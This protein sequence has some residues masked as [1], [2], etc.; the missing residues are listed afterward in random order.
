M[1]SLN[2]KP[3]LLSLCLSAGLVGGAANAQAPKPAAPASAKQVP[4]TPVSMLGG[5]LSFTA[6]PGYE[7]SDL[8]AG[9]AKNGTAGATGRIFVNKELKRVIITTEAPSAVTASDNDSVFLT[10]AVTGYVKQ[11]EQAMPDYKKTGEKSFMVK[12]LGVRQ[13]DSTVK[14]GG[15]PANNTTFLAGSGKQLA[16]IQV[17]TNLKDDGH[18]ALVEQIRA[19]MQTAK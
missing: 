19:S 17:L 14:M 13:I 4:A 15:S 12:T 6:P 9:T 18:A 2:L 10:G 7:G 5:K 11:Q 1:I 8:P 3:A 16:V